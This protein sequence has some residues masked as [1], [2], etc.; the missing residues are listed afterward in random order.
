MI[1]QEEYKKGKLMPNEVELSKELN[2]SRNTLRQAIN[3]LVFGGS[4]SY[5]H[6]LRS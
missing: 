3:R 1:Q 2:I 6:L 4:V 5:T